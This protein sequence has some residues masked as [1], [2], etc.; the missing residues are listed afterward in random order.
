[1]KL[2]SKQKNSL[3]K[4]VIFSII[5]VFCLIYYVIISRFAGTFEWTVY[6]LTTN[7]YGVVVQI[8]NLIMLVNGIIIFLYIV[9]F[10][11]WVIKR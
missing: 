4:L 11:I 2:N 9:V 3:F 8:L 6:E 10:L 5:Q 7:T 1:M